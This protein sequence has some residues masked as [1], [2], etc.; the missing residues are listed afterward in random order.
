MQFT[1]NAKVNLGLFIS[2]KRPDGYHELESLFIPIPWYDEIEF[3]EADQ[4]EF[5]ASGIEIPHDHNGNLISRAYH[6]LQ[7]DYDLPPI[8]IHLNKLIPIGAGLG[9]GSSDAAHMLKALNVHFELN[10]SEAE[11][12]NYAL[13]L[14]SDCPFFIA[15]RPA[16][17]SG[18]GELLECIELPSIP[19]KLLMVVP[20]LHISTAAA[21][22]RIQP[23]AAQYSIKE[24]LKLP[25]QEWSG[26][27]TNDFEQVLQTDFPILGEIRERLES[28]GASFVSMSGSGSAF[29]AFYDSLNAS[30]IGPFPE[31][32]I[33]KQLHLE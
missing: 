25:F 1:A 7:A 10:I 31:G 30:E 8:S 26:K 4:F 6:I 28:S 24:I 20:P 2:S 14:G 22:S 11:L 21:Y 15:N 12:C 3:F 29:Y 13:E 27:L 9:G 16:I 32:S 33:I 19:K 18:R 17:A 5:T 23:K